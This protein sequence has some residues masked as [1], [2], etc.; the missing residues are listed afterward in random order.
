[1][2][3][4]RREG[5]DEDSGKKNNINGIGGGGLELYL[6]ENNKTNYKD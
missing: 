3:K 2:N 1:M 4:R 5:D 6:P